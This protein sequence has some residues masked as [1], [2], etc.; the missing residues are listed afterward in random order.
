MRAMRN[1][2]HAVRRAGRLSIAAEC[3]LRI[4]EEVICSFGE[5]SLRVVSLDAPQH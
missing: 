3:E 5:L 1:M 4:A 2:Q